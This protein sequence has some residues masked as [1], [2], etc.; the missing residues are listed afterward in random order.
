MN[1]L[2]N[3]VG[4]TIVSLLLASPFFLQT[5]N[6]YEKDIYGQRYDVELL[7]DSDEATEQEEEAMEEEEEDEDNDD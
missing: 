4:I 1:N 2:I 5:Q 3:V 7:V 6:A